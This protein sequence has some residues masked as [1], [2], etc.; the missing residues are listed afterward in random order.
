MLEIKPQRGPQEAFLKSTADI[1]IYG[2]GAGGGKSWALLLEA[3]RHIKNPSYSGVIFRRTYP[4]IRNAGGL[5]DASGKLYPLLGARP[6][7][8]S[9]TWRFRAG[10]TVTFRHLKLESDRFSWQGSEIV[11]LAFDELTHFSE[12][13]FWYLLSRNRSTCGVRPYL[14]ATCNPDA[15]SWVRNLINWWIG[16]N[17]LPIPERS[18]VLRHFERVNGD[19]FWHDAPTA[20]SKS[21]TFIPASLYDNPALMSADPDYLKNLK[22]LPLVERERLLQGNWNVKAVAGKVFKPEWFALITELPRPIRRL[23]FWDFAATA[24]LIGNDP[25]WT[26]GVLL[27]QTQTQTIVADMQRFQATPAEVERM[28][29]NTAS[30]DGQATEI[31]WFQDPGQAGLFQT[32]HL[33]AILNGYRA[34]AVTCQL[35]KYNRALPVSRAAEF[36]ELSI[37]TAE[38][39]N[40][41]LNELAQF[42]DGAHDDI[43][44]ALAGGYNTL[45]G[46]YDRKFGQ[47][48]LRYS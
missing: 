12:E 45:N 30:R 3:L 7:E 38:W 41:F 31:C 37:L 46:F 33:T 6:R 43:A 23:R 47:S 4:M 1:V 17:G 5:W 15:D 34:T 22:A 35:S 16:D 28:V 39:N 10:S 11:Y 21:L 26:V 44:D 29:R 9:L 18:G 2:G 19:L 40:P 32:N 27:L 13:Q 42:P 20:D 8:T 14:R 24:K 36:G 48:S 25:D